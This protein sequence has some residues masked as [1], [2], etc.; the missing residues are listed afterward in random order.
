MI[1]AIWAD[2]TL[3]VEGDLDEGQAAVFDRE[4][5]PPGRSTEVPALV[6]PAEQAA[7]GA[8]ALSL[9]ASKAVAA[10]DGQPVAVTGSGLVAS[11][12]RHL[13]REQGRLVGEGGT[14]AAAVVETTGDPSELARAIENVET[15]GTV[16]LAGEPLARTYDLDLYPDV[17]VRGLTLVGI[18]RVES[19]SGAEHARD[20]LQELRTGEALDDAALWYCVTRSPGA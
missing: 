1:T 6:L 8:D 18:P 12:A 13:L 2:D 20:G 14:P 17:H 11:E 9:L 5:A 3:T 4:W 15:M 19:A 7:A 16:V 10:A